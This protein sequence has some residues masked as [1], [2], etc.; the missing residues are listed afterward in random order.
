ME[1]ISE[2]ARLP[3]S[4]DSLQ[5]LPSTS[6]PPSGPSDRRA[7]APVRGGAARLYRRRWCREDRKGWL[8]GY[9]NG[10][11]VIGEAEKRTCLRRQWGPAHREAPR[12]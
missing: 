4:A 9:S 3:G 10:Q 6:I 12:P 8:C 11:P 7:T 1:L 2:L 5:P